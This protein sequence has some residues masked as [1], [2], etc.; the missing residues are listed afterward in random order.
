MTHNTRKTAATSQRLAFTLMELL[1][2]VMIVAVLIVLAFPVISGVRDQARSSQCISNLRQI[3]QAMLL[4]SQDKAGKLP[5]IANTRTN[6]V[7]EMRGSSS[8]EGYKYLTKDIVCEAIRETMTASGSLAGNGYAMNYYIGGQ[9]LASYPEPAKTCLVGEVPWSA[10]Q[11][12]FSFSMSLIY[13]S[14]TRPAL[15]HSDGYHFVFMDGHASSQ[16]D[17]PVTSAYDPFWGR[18]Y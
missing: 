11:R 12:A 6:W 2:V 9:V 14:A 18:Q 10:T 3:G 17:Y 16:D 8:G 4:Y 1:V 13:Q 7:L 15:I 5:V